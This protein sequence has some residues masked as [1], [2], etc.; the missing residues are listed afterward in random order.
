[1]IYDGNI[2]T[3]GTIRGYNEV[4]SATATTEFADELPFS[5][6]GS[7][8]IGGSIRI[9]GTIYGSN[10]S[11]SNNLNT[12][13]TVTSN[14]IVTNNNLSVGKI[15]Y[16]GKYNDVYY[17]GIESTPT[18]FK[19][20]SINGT[21]IPIIV[22]QRTGADQYREITLL[23]S[24]GNTT[25]SGVLKSQ[26]STDATSNG[27][28]AIVAANGG[29]YSKKN[30]YCGA[31]VVAN[32]VTSTLDGNASTASKWRTQRVFKIQDS[33]G[34][35]TGESVNVDGAS[36]VI[37]KLPATIKIN[38]EGNAESATKLET[39][40]TLWGQSFDGTANVSGDISDAKAI[41]ASGVIKT[42][43]ETASTSSSTGALV[44]KGGVGIGGSIN[45][46]E[47]I[48]SGGTISGS[49]FNA[50]SSI[51]AKHDVKPFVS[52]ALDIINATNIVNFVYNND[53][54]GI[55]RTGF[56]AELTS[57]LLTTP[58]HNTMDI[59]SC[60]GMLM[61]AVQELSEENKK[62]RK[63]IENKE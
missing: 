55:L 20:G 28:G 27:T 17:G 9:V 18:S 60:I 13:G 58:E 47:S 14:N 61:K 40:R 46:G 10:I 19:V 5:I 56:I 24:S 50:T 6:K 1:M 62:L 26:N 35:N 7:G 22:S 29:I 11:L 52:S 31:T 42:T 25:T 44:V 57:E 48:T 63:L 30:I 54:K 8:F 51:K 37:L 36:D 33:D 39:E 32:K 23:D 43:D 34:T 38:T 3:Y 4:N 21:N 41:T 59:G 12:S 45:V 16:F 49:L 2:T 15:A 53:E